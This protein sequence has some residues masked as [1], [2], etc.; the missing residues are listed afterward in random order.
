MR[1]LLQGKEGEHNQRHLEESRAGRG[2]S[3][4][5]RGQQTGL[6]TLRDREMGGWGDE[7]KRGR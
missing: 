1:W 6:G 4:L 3:E 5:N 2:R 7:V